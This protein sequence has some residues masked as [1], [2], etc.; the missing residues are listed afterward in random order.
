MPMK[1]IALFIIV[2]FLTS[3]GTDEFPNGIYDYQVE[4][5]LSGGTSKSWTL[6]SSRSNTGVLTPE[7]CSDSVTLIFID[8]ADSLSV[9]E[10]QKSLDCELLADTLAA[11]TTSY[12]RQLFTD[13]LVFSNKVW[14][15]NE[16]TS[17][18]LRLTRESGLQQ[19]FTSN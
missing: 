19:T 14:I 8:V 1:W 6:I 11:N 16:V 9:V 13:S 3:C 18:T 10:Q 15:I 7:L 17:K 2:V 5:L 12:I 4:R